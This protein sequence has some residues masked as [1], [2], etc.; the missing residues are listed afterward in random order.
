MA[1]NAGLMVDGHKLYVFLLEISRV[2]EDA[3]AADDPIDRKDAY[4]P[5]GKQ[6][7][8]YKKAGETTRD[9]RWNRVLR[10]FG[11]GK[12]SVG[13]DDYSYIVG[14]GCANAIAPVGHGADP[15][16]KI[17]DSR[18]F[19]EALLARP[20]VRNRIKKAISDIERPD[21]FVGECVL[22]KR[23]VHA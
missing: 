16:R 14:E 22:R 15:R 5:G 13:K 1:A 21:D 4:A 6:H 19:L 11:R 17:V 12:R 10:Y 20:E 9:D 7:K 3:I 8:P 18:E 23:R 2:L